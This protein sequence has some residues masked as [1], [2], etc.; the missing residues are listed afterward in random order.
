M[1]T[2]TYA[3]L[4]KNNIRLTVIENDVNIEILLPIEAV[5][6][7]LES[8]KYNIEKHGGNEIIDELIN[9]ENNKEN[10]NKKQIFEK[11]YAYLNEI[12]KKQ[13]LHKAR[14]KYFNLKYK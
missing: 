12:V 14:D 7:L 2:Y 3:S 11:D 9:E 8:L 1:S 5:K 10:N 13:E 4:D 6:N